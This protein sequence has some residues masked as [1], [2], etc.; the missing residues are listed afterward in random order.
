MADTRPNITIPAN[1]WVDVYAALNAQVG[2]PS[3]PVGTQIRVKLLGGSEVKLVTQSTQPT[4]LN[5]FDVLV[6]RT[7]PVINDSG[8]SEA[9]AYTVGSDSLINV[10]VVA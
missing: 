9:W 7:T 6:S 2:F 1:T 8:D 4:N 5:A 10:E 3:V